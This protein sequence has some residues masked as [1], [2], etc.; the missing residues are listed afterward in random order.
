MNLSRVEKY[1]RP[2]PFNFEQ[3]PG[4][5]YGWFEIPTSTT[6]PVMYVMVSAADN[7]HEWDHA[8]ISIVGRCATWPE[9]CK[10]KDLLW[11]PEDV[12]I[13]FHPPKSEYVNLA[14]TCLHLWCYRGTL[15]MPRPPKILVG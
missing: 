2:H 13:Q 6:G 8:S 4:D 11:E 9:M 14:K 12:V 1:R 15:P 10:V 5:D 7:E 3:K